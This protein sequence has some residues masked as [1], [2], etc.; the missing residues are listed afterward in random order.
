[1]SKLLKKT[2]WLSATAV[3]VFG[4]STPAAAQ[5]RTFLNGGFELNDPQGSG[6]PKFEFFPDTLVEEWTDDTGIIELWDDGFNSTPAYEGDVF[7]ELNAKQP[8]TLYQEVCLVN[9][10]TVLWSF[11]HRARPG[12]SG[13]N[14]Q[15]V[16]LDLAD[17]TSTAIQTLATQT[18]LLS[19]G[20][21]VNTG[22]AVYTGPTSV[23]RAR[24]RTTDAGSYGNFLDDLQLNIAAFAQLT[25]SAGSDLEASGG[26]LP[27]VQI[28]GRVDTTTTIPVSVTG[29]T[30]DADDF[31]LTA[32]SISIPPGIYGGETFDLPLSITENLVGEANDTIELELGTPSTS[33]ISFQRRECD[34]GSPITS[35]T[36]TIINDDGH[37]QGNKTVETYHSTGNASY[38]LPGND[39]VY[40]IRV[41]N[42][43]DIDIDDGTIFL[44]DKLPEELSF[45][46]GDIDDDGPEINPVKFVEGGSGLTLTYGSDI[47]YSIGATPPTDMSECDAMPATG[48]VETLTYICFAPKGTF[49]AA[50][51]N[52]YFDVSFRMRI[53]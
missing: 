1:M 4:M 53:N 37:L 30:A 40:T 2:L 16:I 46:N 20:W 31:T 32:S 25:T 35:T 52:P 44:V 42:T 51:P 47:G 13:I 19:E 5:Q 17:N 27:S 6:T 12:G 36:Y 24:F 26:N 21:Q 3:M 15:T 39:V 50:D 43:S 23:V 48:Y 28:H 38:A 49:A 41:T 7:G 11:A 34:S 9:G 22:S 10:E 8:G 18:T 14:P 33:E 45:Y 29:G